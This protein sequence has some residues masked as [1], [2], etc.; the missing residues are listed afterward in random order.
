M[1]N[2]V[3]PGEVQSF[4]APNGGVLTGLAYKIGQALVV[5]VASV[6][7]DLPFDGRIRGVFT[8]PKATGQTWSEGALLYWDNSGK[9]FTT[10]A[11]GNRL[12]GWAQAEAATGDTTGSVYLDGAAR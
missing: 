3:Q 1:N 9:K 8:L 7:Q 10:S 2:F 4:T 11:G 12:S 6:A 5:A